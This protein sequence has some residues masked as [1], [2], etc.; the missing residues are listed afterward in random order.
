MK[1]IGLI[2]GMS[3]ES[4]ASYYKLLN[5]G[6]REKIGGFHSAK[7]IMHSV[8]F[9]ELH[10]LQYANRWDEAGEILGKHAKAL[11]VAGADFILICTNTMH[12]VAAIIEKNISIPIIHIAQATADA[13]KEKNCKKSI[14]LGTKFTMSE[15]FNKKILEANGI[16]IVIPDKENINTIN[17]VIFDELVHGKI[18]DASKKKYIEIVKNLCEKDKEIDSVILGCTEIGLLLKKGDINLQIFD[19]A[20]IHVNRALQLAL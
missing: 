6:V 5:E 1:T 20:A 4:T 11:E 2:G 8:D 16:K 7:I 9:D 10:R 12:K 19:T 13:L 15:D 17:S 14:L 18:L 3:W